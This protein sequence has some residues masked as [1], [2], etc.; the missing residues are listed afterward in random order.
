VRGQKKAHV[1]GPGRNSRGEPRKGG[2]SKKKKKV[3]T[4]REKR[5][6]GTSL[7]IEGVV[8]HSQALHMKEG[9]REEVAHP[10]KKTSSGLETKDEYWRDCKGGILDKR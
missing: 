1:L 7:Y 4:R 9:H 6:S 3:P 10:G 8:R 2:G 5:A